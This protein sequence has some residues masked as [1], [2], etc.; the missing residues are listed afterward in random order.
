MLLLTLALFGDPHSRL[1]VIRDAPDF[2]LTTH[3]DKPLIFSKLKGEVR[4]VSFIFTTCNGSCPATT[5]RMAQVQ[6]ALQRLGYE[7]G[8]VDGA[9]GRRTR[10]AVA[11]LPRGE[12][13]LAVEGAGAS[14]HPDLEAGE[15]G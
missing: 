6:E 4:L 3:D 15:I 14:L 13:T 10:A 8:R 5:H 1:A 12:F 7:P 9:F 11:R 2:E